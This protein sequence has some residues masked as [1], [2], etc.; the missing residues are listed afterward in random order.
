M[1][2]TEKKTKLKFQGRKRSKKGI[3]SMLLALLSLAA[4]ITASVLSGMAKGAG[5]SFLGYIGIGALFVSVLGFLLGVRSFKQ[6]DIL[7]FH[8]VFG[9]VLNGLLLIVYLSLYLIGMFI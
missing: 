2:K 6:A 7:Y 5:G 4:L 8:P 3:A 9:A 1:E